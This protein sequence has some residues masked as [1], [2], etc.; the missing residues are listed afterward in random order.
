MKLSHSITE[1]KLHV[2]LVAKKR[3]CWL[4]T[5]SVQDEVIHAC[6]SANVNIITIGTAKNHV[7]LL[8]EA[9]PVRPVCKQVEII[10]S[11]SSFK[12]GKLDPNWEGWRT[13]YFLNSVGSKSISRVR[14]YIEN[15]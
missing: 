14:K 10:K 13:G 3:H 11:V 1:I 5:Y 6:A 7:H 15:Q 9:D 12:L 8:F 4:D 2:C